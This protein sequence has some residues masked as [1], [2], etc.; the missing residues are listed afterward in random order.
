L[1]DT[2]TTLAQG[3]HLL[4]KNPKK[5]DPKKIDLTAGGENAYT[6]GE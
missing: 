3:L 1:T 4:K 2:T 6:E 5:M